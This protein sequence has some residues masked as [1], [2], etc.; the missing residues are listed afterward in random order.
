MFEAFLRGD[1]ATAELAFNPEVEWDGTNLPDGKISRGIDAVRDH[2]ARWRDAWE[3]WEL[4]LED[5]IDGGG[6][7][8][9]VMFRERGRTKAGMDINERHSELYTVRDGKI[10]SRKAYSEATRALLDAGLIER[11]AQAD[12]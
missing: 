9:I 10:I 2:V 6:D 12:R 1:V 4:E 8:A 5:V 7:R 3:T 11:P